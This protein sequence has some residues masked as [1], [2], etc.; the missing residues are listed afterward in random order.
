M[1]IIWQWDRW[2]RPLRHAAILLLG[3]LLDWAA[4]DGLPSVGP[5]LAAHEPLGPLAGA[6]LAQLVL[7]LTPLVRYSPDAAPPDAGRAR[8]LLLVGVA[9]VGLLA[10]SA[11]PAL[12]RARPGRLV[13]PEVTRAIGGCGSDHRTYLTVRTLLGDR[14][15]WTASTDHAGVSVEGWFDG[16]WRR[17][18]QAAT[19]DGG[20]LADAGW[21]RWRARLGSTTGPALDALGDTCGVFGDAPTTKAA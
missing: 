12:A 1:N 6:V 2:P 19:P 13:V 9:V 11:G 10:A 18:T 5:W 4:R 8:T 7:V 14:G 15:T 16:A 21:G 3:G 17:P 20:I